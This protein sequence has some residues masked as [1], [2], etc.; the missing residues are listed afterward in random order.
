MARTLDRFTTLTF[1][2]YGTLI[3]WETGIWDA[4]QPLLMAN[5]ADVVRATALEAFG[6]AESAIETSEPRMPYP[7]VLTA[8][9]RALAKELGLKTTP[10]LDADFG[11]SLPHWPAF[12]DTAGA[13]RKLKRRYRLVIL[14]NVHRA[15]F[16]AS[17]RKLG[18]EFDAI[19]TAED[20]GSYK[21]DA[22]NFAYLL[23]H[24]KA[25]LG[26]RPE[27][28]LHT[29]QSLFHDHAP[30]RAAG[31]ANAWIDRQGLSTGDNWGATARLAERPHCD[32]VFPDLKSLAA[33]AGLD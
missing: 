18:V 6:R 1:D 5:R 8:S 30:A 32:F 21:P 25:D 33:A 23:E 29:A 11:R 17:N 14:S 16:A 24:L 9:H 3:D 20:I 26:T 31:L 12:A 15:G 28:I 10:D 7:E 2:C 19:Y 13:L 27:D 4:L 22:R